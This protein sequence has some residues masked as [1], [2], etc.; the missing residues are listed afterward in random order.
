MVL[1]ALE[2]DDR[3]VA[4]GHVL[5]SSMSVHVG[6]MKV[7]EL[8]VDSQSML[9]HVLVVTV[10]EEMNIEPL[11]GHKPAIKATEGSCT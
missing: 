11:S 9:E 5:R 6:E 10:Q 1:R 4:L 3:H 7:P 8:T 2:P